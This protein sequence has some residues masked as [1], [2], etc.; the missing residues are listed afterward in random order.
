VDAARITQAWE[1]VQIEL[2]A[3]CHAVVLCD[4]E[5][6]E[7]LIGLTD[8]RTASD[9][10][11]FLI[12][13]EYQ[14]LSADDVDAWLGAQT[15]GNVT[16]GL[17]DLE[18][19]LDRCRFREAIEVI[20]ERIAQGMTYQVNYTY[21]LRFKTFGDPIYL[22]RKLRTRQPVQYGA[23]FRLPDD[24]FVLSLSPEL[25]VR[26]DA[27][28]LTTRPMKGTARRTGDIEADAIASAAL[29]NDA[30]NRAENLM[31]VDLLRND[32]GR[33]AATGSVRVTDLFAVE[34]VGEVLQMSSVIEADLCENNSFPDILAALFPCG[35]ITGA[36][37]RR[38]MELI[39]EL[40]PA[41]RGIYTGAIGWI[42]VGTPGSSFAEATADA[43]P[44]TEVPRLYPPN[45]KRE[46]PNAKR[47]DG[48]S[49]CLSVAIRTLALEPAGSDGLRKGEMGVG[50]GILYESD[51]D[52]EYE[53][54]RLKAGF[55]TG[56]DPGFVL[57]ETMAASRIEGCVLLARHIARLRAS[58]R[59]FGF[60]L[61]VDAVR[62]KIERT[63]GELVA[64]GVHRIRLELNHGG[65]VRIEVAPLAPLSSPVRVLLATD[66]IDSRDLFLYHKTSIRE[67]YNRALEEAK[68]SAAFDVL[69]LNERG[70][71]TEGA[72][73]NVFLREEG[74][75]FTP[76]V[77]SGLL[78]GVMRSVLLEDQELRAREK[79]LTR[80]DLF[81]ADEVW[82]CNALRG[83]LRVSGVVEPKETVF[84][85][86]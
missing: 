43:S 82:V 41:P 15:P 19:N 49:F 47:N 10:L 8:A 63:I 44:G 57:I 3:G 85:G 9:G 83:A 70:E 17:I 12:Y 23:L 72:R 16:A 35:S 51:P 71:I 86:R 11:R 84:S 65:A 31:I 30:K 53:E 50:A 61:D 62:L 7:S 27:G 68:E 38:T 75:W 60:R 81:A 76:P 2:A 42:E 37:K 21:R 20:R 73:S 32:L 55:L 22:Y 29:A 40:E 79:V 46:T 4:Y 18:P 74:D 56:M 64:D 6:G 33:V 58:A 45:A 52:A 48:D 39:R 67:R 24:R 14:S 78:P 36:P 66:S 1:E 77:E 5:F 28:H 54:C 26:S 80:D 34:P 59:K 13:R 25:F 69:F